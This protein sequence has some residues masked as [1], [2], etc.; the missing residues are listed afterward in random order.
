M[1]LSSTGLDDAAIVA[2]T[3]YSAE[4]S[5]PPAAARAARRRGRFGPEEANG[6]LTRLSPWTREL[7]LSVEACSPAGAVLRLPRNPRILRTGGAVSGHALV[8]CADAAMA[9]ALMGHLGEQKNVVTVSIAVDFMR[10]IAD[11]EATLAATVRRCGRTLVFT[12]CTF[13]EP[14]IPAIAVHATATWA[15]VDAAI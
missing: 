5:L 9:I 6:F 15:F 13:I 12:E 8:A 4:P 7:G 14:G 10:A 2:D 11:G 3:T 1:N